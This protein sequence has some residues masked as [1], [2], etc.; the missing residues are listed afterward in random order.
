MDK[1]LSLLGLSSG[2]NQKIVNEFRSM[3][4]SLSLKKGDYF[5]KEGKIS[6]RIGFLTSGMLKQYYIINGEEKIRWILI[7]N[8]IALSLRSFTKSEPSNEYIEAI[9][10]CSMYYISRENWVYLF[11]KYH[12]FK[13]LWLKNL[14]ETFIGYEERIFDLISKPAKQRYESFCKKFPEHVKQIPLQYM[15]S[16]LGIAPQHLSRIRKSASK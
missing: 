12:P 6:D 10:K 5:L 13:L 1:L 11:N 14:E 9:N 15:A 4:V 16:I 2:L 7:K 8:E 3:L